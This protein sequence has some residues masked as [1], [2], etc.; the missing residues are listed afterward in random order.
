MN[1]RQRIQSIL[2]GL[3]MLLCCA[4]MVLAP[5]AGYF[6]AAV[7]IILSMLFYGVKL[8]IYYQAMARHMVGGKAMLFLG[9]LVL[10]FGVFVT[11]MVDTPLL[12]LLLYLVLFNGFSGAISLLRAMEARRFSALSWIWNLLAGAVSVGIALAAIVAALVL[13]S[14]ELLGYLYCAGML[15][16]ALVRIGSAFRRTE[17]VYIQ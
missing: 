11:S 17:L 1:R 7:I 3:G 6:L 14:L 13:H 9:I 16:A 8:L 4:V 10:N 12:F 5:E 15:Y 2:T